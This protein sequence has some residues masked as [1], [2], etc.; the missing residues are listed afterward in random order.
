MIVKYN[1]ATSLGSANLFNSLRKIHRPDFGGGSDSRK[2]S[3]AFQASLPLFLCAQ[4]QFGQL[5]PEPF[6]DRGSSDPEST[7]ALAV[8]RFEQVRHFVYS[9]VLSRE[10]VGKLALIHPSRMSSP[11]G[12]GGCLGRSGLRVDHLM[13]KQAVGAGDS[14]KNRSISREAQGPWASVNDP[15]GLPPDQAWPSPSMAQYSAWGTP[16]PS[17]TRVR[18]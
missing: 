5:P 2:A 16:R 18:V 12:A 1:I 14:R 11:P 15:S 3:Q 10:T 13:L 17:M 7:E 4:R 9:A 6:A 8:R